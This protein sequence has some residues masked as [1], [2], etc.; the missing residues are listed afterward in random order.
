MQLMME[1][2]MNQYD[3]MVNIHK[4]NH[5]Y[6]CEK[7]CKKVHKPAK[8]Q[9]K[10]TESE[11]ELVQEEDMTPTGDLSKHESL[12]EKLHS[13]FSELKELNYL[14]MKSK[15]QNKESKISYDDIGCMCLEWNY[16]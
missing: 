7:D 4:Q 8:K 5:N 13:Q 10:A 3:Y 15:E 16:W 1:R 12:V 11:E 2:E 6:N 9:D 14:W